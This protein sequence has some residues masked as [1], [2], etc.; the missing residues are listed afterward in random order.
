MTIQTRRRTAPI[1]AHA[2]TLPVVREIVIG[3]GASTGSPD[4]RSLE[5]APADATA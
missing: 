1:H 3:T 2:Y 5:P 4:P